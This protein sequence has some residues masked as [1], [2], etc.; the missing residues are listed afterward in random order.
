MI[1]AP[2]KI[3]G[4]L[5]ND[6]ITKLC[7]NIY[8][9]GDGPTN[10]KLA[11]EL[12]SVDISKC[13]FLC[14]VPLRIRPPHITVPLEQSVKSISARIHLQVAGLHTLSADGCARDT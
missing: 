6:S 8:G 12:S 14:I 1:G 10:L 7:L 3:N 4:S 2:G 5:F 9:G 11:L 13:A